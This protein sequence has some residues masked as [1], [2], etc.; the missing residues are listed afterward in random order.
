MIPKTG[1]P[2]KSF[3]RRSSSSFRATPMSGSAALPIT[4]FLRLRR[5]RFPCEARIFGFSHSPKGWRRVVDNQITPP[6]T[7]EELLAAILVE[8]SYE[9]DEFLSAWLAEMD[10]ERDRGAE[11]RPVRGL[12]LA[13][14]GGSVAIHQAGEVH[15]G[16]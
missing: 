4:C 2:E 5:I 8:L 11:V 12:R 15:H 14:E 7:R 13:R 1:E 16:G 3:S 10:R 9:S 6:R